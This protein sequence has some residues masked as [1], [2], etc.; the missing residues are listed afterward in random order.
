MALHPNLAQ[1]YTENYTVVTQHQHLLRSSE[2]P[3]TWKAIATHHM[4]Y[5]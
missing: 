4:Q 1:I 5:W 3:Q 2:N